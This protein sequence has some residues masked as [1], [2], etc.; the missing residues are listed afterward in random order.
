MYWNFTPFYSWIV[1][2][3]K[4]MPDNEHLD[5]FQFFTITHKVAMNFENK[6]F[7]EHVFIAFG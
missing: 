6:S 4:D 2:H 1:F 3:C 7:C 5:R